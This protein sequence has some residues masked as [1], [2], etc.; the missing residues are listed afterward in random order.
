MGCDTGRIGEYKCVLQV[1]ASW[2][3]LVSLAHICAA[4]SSMQPDGG[5]KVLLRT[6]WTAARVRAR[7]HVDAKLG[8]KTITHLSRRATSIIAITG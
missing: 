3:A 8:K 2:P 4:P 7:I 5:K 6:E 1:L